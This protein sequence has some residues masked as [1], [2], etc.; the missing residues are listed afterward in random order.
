MI[1]PA[2]ALMALAA[3]VIWGF[4]YAISGRLLQAG[5]SPSFVIMFSSII[6]MPVYLYMLFKVDGIQHNINIVL[7]NKNFIFLMVVQG[8][9]IIAGI[10]LIYSAI[11][12]KNATYASV[13]EISYPLFVFFF[14]W[15]L[16][17]DV[18]MSWEVALGGVL[19]F[20]GVALVLLRAGV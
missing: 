18:H 12:Q 13:I 6:N 19:I 16:F 11:Q 1:I 7:E 2:W 3:S 15:L 8:L 14:S 17:R 20:S 5:M 9:A 10:F 4:S